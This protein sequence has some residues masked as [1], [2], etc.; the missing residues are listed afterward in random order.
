VV[1]HSNRESREEEYDL[2]GNV[3][4]ELS[5]DG[6]SVVT[7]T[8]YYDARGEM[9]GSGLPYGMGESRQY[10]ADGRLLWDDYFYAAGTEVSLHPTQERPSSMNI[11]G[12]LEQATIYK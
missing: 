9:T 4:T 8:F 11:G 6:Q 10:D 2:A 12:W 1:S 5:F 7:Q 3:T